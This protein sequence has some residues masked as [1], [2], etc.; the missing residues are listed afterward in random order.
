M[1]NDKAASAAVCMIISNVD[2]FI[3]SVFEAIISL[4]Y[5]FFEFIEI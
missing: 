5:F 2:V 3:N 4:L 1:A